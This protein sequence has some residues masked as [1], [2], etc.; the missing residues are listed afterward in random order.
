MNRLL[1][2]IFLVLSVADLSAKKVTD[3]SGVYLTQ[4][5]FVSNRLQYISGFVA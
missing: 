5:D 3:T 4:N 2:I 1:L